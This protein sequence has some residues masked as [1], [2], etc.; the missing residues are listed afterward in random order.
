[1]PLGGG[2]VTIDADLEIKFA[3]RAALHLAT[4]REQSASGDCSSRG[5][6]RF[7]RLAHQPLLWD[8]GEGCP[9]CV[10]RNTSQ[11]E[12]ERQASPRATL[13]EPNLAR[14]GAFCSRL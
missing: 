2:L 6:P 11:R 14:L 13:G 5:V 12:G 7:S 3:D 1:M 9:P 4:Y 8:T 10:A